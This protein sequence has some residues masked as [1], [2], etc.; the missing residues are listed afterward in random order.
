MKD[1]RSVLYL[2]RSQSCDLTNA[3]PIVESH[4]EVILILNTHQEKDPC[5]ITMNATCVKAKT[6]HI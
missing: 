4:R 1:L 2:N 5:F 6:G 3:S